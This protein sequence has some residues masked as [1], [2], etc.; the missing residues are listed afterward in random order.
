MN[1]LW[2]VPS[3]ALRVRLTLSF[4]FT[5]IVGPGLASVVFVEP[6]PVAASPYRVNVCVAAREG[7]IETM[8]TIAASTTARHAV[9]AL[10]R[11]IAAGPKS[12]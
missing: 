12:G 6:Q 3:V 7:P 4:R 10:G 11:Y 8:D 1:Q 2:F 5:R 9:Q